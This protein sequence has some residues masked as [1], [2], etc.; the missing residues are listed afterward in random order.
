MRPLNLG[1]VWGHAPPE[2]FEIWKL[3]NAIS[4]ILGTKLS[5]K[6]KGR[7]KMAELQQNMRGV[8]LAE[9]VQLRF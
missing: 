2:N 1:G 8:S 4:S 5:A 7:L 6:D 9:S 3:W